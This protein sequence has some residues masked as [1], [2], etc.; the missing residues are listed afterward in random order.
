MTLFTNSPSRSSGI[1]GELEGKAEMEVVVVFGIPCAFVTS[2]ALLYVCYLDYIYSF[3]QLVL[4]VSQQCMGHFS[5]P[6]ARVCKWMGKKCLKSGWLVALVTWGSHRWSHEFLIRRAR[7]LK[8]SW[9]RVYGTDLGASFVWD[10][11]HFCLVCMFIRGCLLV[12]IVRL[13]SNLRSCSLVLSLGLQHIFVLAV[14][15]SEIALLTHSF[16][17]CLFLAGLLFQN[18]FFLR[19]N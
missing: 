8:F 16:L 2:P 6:W 17:L 4:S 13:H 9:K 3:S 7:D 12:E 18:F 14:Q 19:T 15:I 5:V 11:H 1:E 10:T